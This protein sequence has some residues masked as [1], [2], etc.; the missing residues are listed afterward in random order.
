ML[1][2]NCAAELTNPAD[3][4]NEEFWLL[5]GLRCFLGEC[6]ETTTPTPQL[7]IGSN[8]AVTC[9]NLVS[10]SVRCWGFGGAGQLGHDVATN[11]GDGVGSSI[12][13]A[14]N[15]PIGPTTTAVGAGDNHTCALLS[16]GAIRCWGQGSLGQLGHNIN[17]NIGEG[18]QSII[19]AGD[20]PVGGTVTEVS[21]GGFHTCAVLAGGTVRCWGHGLAGKLGY[22]AVANIGDGG[23]SIIAAG[24]VP[25]GNT[26]KSISAGGSHSCALLT[27]GAV[28]CWGSGGNGVLGYNAVTPVGDGG[29]SIIAA[30]DVPVGG[31]VTQIAS[32]F[33]HTC[34]LLST[35]AVRCWGF[36][37]SGRLGYNAIANVGDGGT[38]IIAAGDVPIG[39][40][41]S[42]IAAGNSHTCALLSSGAVRCWGLGSDGRLGHNAT[43]NIGDG[44]T[45]I[46]AAGDVP[47]G[48]YAVAIAT[49]DEHSCAVLSTGKVRCWGGGLTGRLG[50]GNTNSIADG[51][52]ISIIAAGDVPFE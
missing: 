10:N 47:L 38:S 25:V 9:L 14:G 19:A 28:R 8:S 20:I 16:S 43:T 37:A 30:G 32:G 13:S 40:T 1:I 15:V 24:D 39:G 12:L 34:A 26:V 21:A 2:S 48:G 18:T 51:I 11:I 52:G 44:G 4:G 42:Q 6:S 50:Y 29:T 31:S 17:T 27:T 41:V 35:G 3:P 36:G 22:N 49:G 7:S 33:A 46:I 23:T 5:L 45:S